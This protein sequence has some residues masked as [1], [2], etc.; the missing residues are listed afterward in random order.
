MSCTA[1][2]QIPNASFESWTAATGYSTPDGWGN[3][4]P[5]TGLSGTYT[6]EKGTSGA[7]SGSSFLKLTTKNC[8]IVVPGVSV[9]GTVNV[10]G[11][12]VTITGGFPNTTRPA[13]LTGQYQYM[14]FGTSDKPHVIALLWKWNVAASKRDTVAFVDSA[15]AGM[16]MSWVPISVNLNYSR[17]SVPDSA[18][19]ILSSSNLPPASGATINSFLYADNLAFAGNVPSGVVTVKNNREETTVYPNPAT[20][21]ATIYYYSLFSANAKVILTDMGGRT[22]RTFDEE[23][24]SGANY[25]ELDLSGLVKGNYLAT[26]CNGLGTETKK[27]EIR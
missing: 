4:N 17:G 5:Y 15:L 3:T 22:V 13:T 2:A 16:Q 25:F 26:I 23:M 11:T 18:I 10:S 6:C 24:S 7:P 12:T 9:S 21:A 8:G 1:M 27:I 14:S 20:G 19:I